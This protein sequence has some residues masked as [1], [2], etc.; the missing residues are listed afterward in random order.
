MCLDPQLPM[1]WCREYD[2]ENEEV[3]PVLTPSEQVQLIV[4]AVCN[5]MKH[6]SGR[7]IVLRSQSIKVLFLIRLQLKPRCSPYSCINVLP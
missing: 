5:T 1:G 3:V 4:Q 7:T 2:G 6:N